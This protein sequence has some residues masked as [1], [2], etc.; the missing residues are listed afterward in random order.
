MSER[1]A[2]TATVPCRVI[3]VGKGHDG[4]LMVAVSINDG[5]LVRFPASIEQCKAWVGLLM[6]GAKVLSLTVV[7]PA[8]AAQCFMLQ[9]KD[10]LYAACDEDEPSVSWVLDRDGATRFDKAHEAACWV[11]LAGRGAECVKVAR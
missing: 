6:D 10:G 11:F 5:P 4:G 2:L 1:N 3:E 7:E 8:A 9:S